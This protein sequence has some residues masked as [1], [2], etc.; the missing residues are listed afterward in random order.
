MMVSSMNA[1]DR[2]LME[3]QDASGEKRWTRLLNDISV[4]Q[5]FSLAACCDRIV[6]SVMLIRRGIT[7]IQLEFEADDK[8]HVTVQDPTTGD[9]IIDGYGDVA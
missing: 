3:V 6:T 5:Q 7:P 4:I 1:T 9:T 2:F 8:L